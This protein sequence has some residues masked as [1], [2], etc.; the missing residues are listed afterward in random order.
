MS[1]VDTPE[2]VEAMA[3]KLTRL[4]AAF[5]PCTDGFK[6]AAAMLLR[7]HARAVDWQGMAERAEE[8]SMH[9]Q[10]TAGEYLE[11][12]EKAEA[13]LAT[14]RA[15]ALREAAFLLSDKLMMTRAN[16]IDEASRLEAAARPKPPTLAEAVRAYRD[17]LNTGQHV[18]RNWHAV[19]QALDRAE[20]GQ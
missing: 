5:A 11:R 3:V 10:N 16:L 4:D 2:E 18:E 6:V 15:D 12:A 17:S 8:R 13:A 7:L 1:T 9:W 19:E 14:A 20:A